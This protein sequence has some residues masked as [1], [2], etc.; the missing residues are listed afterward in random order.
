MSQH[1]ISVKVENKFG[2]LAR[3]SGLFSARGYNIDSLAVSRTENEDISVMTIVVNGD[4]RILEQVKK[5]LNKLIDVIKVSDHAVQ[6]SVQ[7]ELALIKLNCPAAKRGEI[8]QLAELFKAEVADISL[9][10]IT[11]S[12]KGDSEKIDRFVELA[13]PYGIKESMRTGLVSILKERD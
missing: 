8:L 5:Q 1:V 6:S 10:T 7:R 12:I 4:D 3:V 2:V 11:F 13:S 9:K